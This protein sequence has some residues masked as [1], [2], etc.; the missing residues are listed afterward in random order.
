MQ[1]KRLPEESRHERFVMS[2]DQADLFPAS[3][4]TFSSCPINQNKQWGR[5]FFFV[6]LASSRVKFS[7]WCLG[8][9]QNARIWR[10]FVSQILHF[11]G[12]G[13]Q[14]VSRFF[15]IEILGHKSWTLK[16]ISYQWPDSEA[17]AGRIVSH[18]LVFKIL[19]HKMC[20]DYSIQ[21]IWDTRAA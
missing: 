1:R 2:A 12:F 11:Q 4:L 21:R 19:G 3:S 6:E 20:P 10:L 18:F 8:L 5:M 16:A 9:L 7:F 13:I 14:N 17:L 15:Y